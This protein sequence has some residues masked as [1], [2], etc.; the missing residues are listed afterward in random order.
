MFPIK[1]QPVKTNCSLKRVKR[2]KN[3]TKLFNSL[4]I[5]CIAGEILYEKKQIAKANCSSS[6]ERKI[7][8]Q[9]EYSYE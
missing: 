5:V 7:K 9:M 8:L 3:W 6:R 1:E 4:S 2:K